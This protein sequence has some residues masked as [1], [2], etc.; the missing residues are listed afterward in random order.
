MVE[1]ASQEYDAAG[2]RVSTVEVKGPISS[3]LAPPYNSNS[4][5]Q[6]VI[7][8]SRGFKYVSPWGTFPLHTIN[9]PVLCNVQSWELFNLVMDKTKQNKSCEK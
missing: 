1:K 9:N 6:N 5:F 3:I 8:T 2:H 7:T 4:A